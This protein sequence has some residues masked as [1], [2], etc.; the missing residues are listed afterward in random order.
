MV[1][2]IIGGDTV[3]ADGIAS[4][5][6]RLNAVVGE[7]GWSIDDV[8]DGLRAISVKAETIANT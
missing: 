7:L 1:Y 8:L 2:F 5:Q 4:D 6:L 3:K